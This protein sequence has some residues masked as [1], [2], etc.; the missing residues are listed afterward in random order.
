MGDL[1]VE[2][3]GSDGRLFLLFGG[4][5]LGL[6]LLVVVLADTQ[7]CLGSHDGSDHASLLRLVVIHPVKE[8]SGVGVG[9]KNIE[10]ADG[11][12]VQ[13]LLIGHS[14]DTPTEGK[15]GKLGPQCSI[16]DAESSHPPAGSSPHQPPKVLGDVP[17]TARNRR[18]ASWNFP[19][20]LQ[21]PALLGK[22]C[23]GGRSWLRC[24]TSP[25]EAF[26]SFRRLVYRLMSS[27]RATASPAGTTSVS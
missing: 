22:H 27:V 11:H 24:S 20:S 17:L 5:L 2:R 23:S 16:I 14:D 7:P 19:L 9:G 15:S 12:V 8:G 1:F 10:L 13:R 21:S 18:P 6:E 26:P 4:F 25:T 3:F